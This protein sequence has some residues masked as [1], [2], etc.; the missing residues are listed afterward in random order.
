M[1]IRGGKR[2]VVVDKCSHNARSLDFNAFRSTTPPTS[3][4]GRAKRSETDDFIILRLASVPIPPL[5]G[6]N[7]PAQSLHVASLTWVR[8]YRLSACRNLTL[9]HFSGRIINFAKRMNHPS[10]GESDGSKVLPWQHNQPGKPLR[11]RTDIFGG[12]FVELGG[13]TNFRRSLDIVDVASGNLL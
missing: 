5:R 12:V 13:L 8:G 6:A 3:V 1:V 2:P 11:S 10:D 4:I 9:N 7:R